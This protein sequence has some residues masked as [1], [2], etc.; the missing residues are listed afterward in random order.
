MSYITLR[1]K[2]KSRKLLESSRKLLKSSRK[3]LKS[4]RKLLKSSRKL[5]REFSQP[6]CFKILIKWSI[7]INRHT[8]GNIFFYLAENNFFKLFRI[9]G[10]IH[11]SVF[12]YRQMAYYVTER[13]WV[14]SNVIV[15][16]YNWN[17]IINI[18]ITTQQYNIINK[19]IDYSRL[20]IS[21]VTPLYYILLLSI[22]YYWHYLLINL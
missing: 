9:Y 14:N 3:L 12:W 5:L 15:V 18:L 21:T 1:I 7:Y 8:A 4:S 13:P 10:E 16:Y 6:W 17:N 19:Q 22:I 20:R 2:Y 11:N